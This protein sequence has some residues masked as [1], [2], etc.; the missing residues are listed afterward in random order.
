MKNN[1]KPK[2]N[3]FIPGQYSALSKNRCFI[4]NF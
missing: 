4:I 2:G 1:G 3:E